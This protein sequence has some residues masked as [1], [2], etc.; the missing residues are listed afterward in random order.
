MWAL[1]FTGLLVC[2]VMRDLLRRGIR[3]LG[4]RDGSDHFAVEED[5]ALA[6]AVAAGDTD[7]GPAGF[8]GSVDPLPIT[9]TR[10]G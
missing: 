1:C 9:V 8:T 7:V 10:N 3:R 5:L 2:A 6:L 4:V